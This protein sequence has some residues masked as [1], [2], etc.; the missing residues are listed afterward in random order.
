MK[1][2]L[3]LTMHTSPLLAVSLVVLLATTSAST[4]APRPST[5]LQQAIAAAVRARSTPKGEAY[6]ST[7]SDIIVRMMFSA[8]KDCRVINAPG[9]PKPAGFQCVVIIGKTGKPK[10]IIRDSRDPTAQCFYAKLAKLAY[11]PPPAD[12]WPVMFGINTPP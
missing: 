7:V 3:H 4:A 12:N 9:V 8:I 1:R 6:Q 11:P 5:Q 2:C 10:S